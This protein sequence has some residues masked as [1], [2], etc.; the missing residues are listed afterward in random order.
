MIF[1][2]T[3]IEGAFVVRVEPVQDERG[4]FGRTFCQ[5]EFRARGLVPPVAQA[6]VSWNRRR[7][8]LRGMHYQVKPHEEIKLVRCTRGAVWDV[9]VDLRADSPTRWRWNGIEL[10]AENR[11]AV[12]IPEG[13]AH[14]FQTLC[15][16]S[17][18]FY[19]MS[20]PYHAEFA[21]GV[22]W[23][24]PVVGIDWPIADP[25]LS[26]RDRGHPWLPT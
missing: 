13:V 24:D 7:G 26:D 6:S 12:Y 16:E 17:E 25:I 14:G 2:P 22:A 8:T 18:L 5:D 3:P 9:I 15:D 11:L 19:Q 10:N 23:N 21:R 1:E 4:F 20:I